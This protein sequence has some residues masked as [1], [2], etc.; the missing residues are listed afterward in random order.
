MFLILLKRDH[1]AQVQSPPHA[2]KLP[3]PPGRKLLQKLDELQREV[4]ALAVFL[5]MFPV[6]LYATY[7]S[8]LYFSASSIGW[9]DAAVYSAVGLAAV[10]ITGARLL[11]RL[12]KRRVLRLGYDGAT[13]VGQALN[14]LMRD[15]F[16]VWHDFS[17]DGVTIDHVVVSEKGVFAVQ[18]QARSRPPSNRFS[19]AATVEYNG[20][21][22]YFPGGKDFE[23]IEAAEHRAGRLAKWIGDSVGEPVAVRAIVALPGWFVKRTTAEGIPVANPNQFASLFEHVKP[24]RLSEETMTRIVDQLDRWCRDRNSAYDDLC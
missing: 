13:L 19:Q 22:L 21:M 5:F 6:L 12:R 24:R 15:G 8:Q 20:R 3:R 2:D 9:V 23:T 18:N 7:M 16:Y 14:K 17:A 11:Q 4:T 1:R 10:T